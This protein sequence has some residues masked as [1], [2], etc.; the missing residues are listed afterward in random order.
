MSFAAGLISVYDNVLN[1][2]FMETLPADE[3]NPFASS[4]IDAVGVVGLV[5]IKAVTTIVAVIIMCALSFTKYRTAIIGV[6]ILQCLLF[7][8]LTFY[9]P[10][11][12]FW[13]NNEDLALPIKLFWRFYTE[14]EIPSLDMPYRNNLIRAS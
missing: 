3:Q 8:Y 6:F 4:I 1:V 7:F 12:N 14:G 2:I 10:N 9:T 5:H 11:G 13:G